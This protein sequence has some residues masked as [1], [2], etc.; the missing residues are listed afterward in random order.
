MLIAGSKLLFLAH[1]FITQN[2]LQL[3]LITFPLSPHFI[4]PNITSQFIR[5]KEGGVYSI[6]EGNL[7]TKRN[8]N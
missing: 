8:K 5:P 4:R 1:N 2:Y 6:T 7:S 3:R